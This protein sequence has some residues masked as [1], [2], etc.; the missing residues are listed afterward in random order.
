MCLKNW[1]AVV[2]LLSATGVNVAGAAIKPTTT[3]AAQT[4]NNT[5]AAN[6]FV[7]QTNG[8]ARPGNVSK[9]DI[10]SLL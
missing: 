8:N 1:Y 3:L 4:A 10:H 7:G 9:V 6:S 5:S 2:L